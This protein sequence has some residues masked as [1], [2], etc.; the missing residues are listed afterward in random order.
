MKIA[1]PVENGYLHEHFGGCRQF[2]LVE[3]D[4]SSK[5]APRTDVVVAP[6]HRPGL[7]PIWLKQQGV[8]V[9]IADGIGRRA[10]A[11]LEHNGIAVRAGIPGATV[12][13]LIAS[14]LAGHFTVAPDGCAHHG[15]MHHHDH[16]HHHDDQAHPIDGGGH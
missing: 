16:G 4:A 9:V 5:T 7:F 15:H 6:E 1:I 13:E 14:Y 12:A 8:Q 10:L 11:L 2:A 3:V